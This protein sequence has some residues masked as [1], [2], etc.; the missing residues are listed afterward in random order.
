MRV[1]LVGMVGVAL[2][3]EPALVNATRGGLTSVHATLSGTA[4]SGTGLFSLPVTVATTEIGAGG[5]E[6]VARSDVDLLE[7]L[8]GPASR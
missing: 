3:S 2:V 1:V 8:G 5:A 4:P 6:V 7:D